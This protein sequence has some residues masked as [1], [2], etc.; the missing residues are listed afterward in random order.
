LKDQVIWN[1]EIWVTW[2]LSIYHPAT[3]LVGLVN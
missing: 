1:N 2:F 3:G